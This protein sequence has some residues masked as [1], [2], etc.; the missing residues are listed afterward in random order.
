MREDVID[1]RQV[2]LGPLLASLEVDQ[3]IRF[4]V[5]LNAVRSQ[6][7]TKKRVAVTD[8]DD[9]VL[10]GMQRLEA[11]GLSRIELSDQPTT[12]LAFTG[13]GP[14]WAAQY[15]G[16][17]SVGNSETLADAVRQ[18]IGRAKAY[19]CGLLSLAPVGP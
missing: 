1:L 8:P 7:T 9:L 2:G 12:S 3:L 5:V 11:A 18:G 16:Y 15:D 13:K 10:W 17:A 6:T 14:V 4:R 19:G